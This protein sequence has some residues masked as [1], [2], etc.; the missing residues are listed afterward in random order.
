MNSSNISEDEF[1]ILTLLEENRKKFSQR[2]LA[3]KLQLSLGK[4]NS[5]L[6]EMEAKGFVSKGTITNEGLAALEPY[7]VKRVI[8]LAAGFGSRLIPVTLN[9]PK[10]LIRVKGERII[11]SMI[12]VFISNGIEEI[13]IVRGHLGDQFNQLLEKYPSI[14]FIENPIYNE[15]NNISSAFY[16]KDLLENAYICEADIILK[17]PSLIK[18]YQYTSNYCGV[19]CD[20]TDD[21]CL[22]TNKGKISGV[23]VGGKNGYRMVG[24]SYWTQE[25]GKL[26]SEKI[27]E[28]FNQP[29]GREKYW[30]DVP[31]S[32]FINDFNL[33]IRECSFDDFVEIDTFNELKAVDSVYAS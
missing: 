23:S 9:T 18:K 16:A 1:Q 28:I 26:L 3:K 20:V 10:A 30:D 24:I 13:Y 2:E 14:K 31:L 19:K 11:D 33:Y 7:R 15:S 8:F 5:L 32:C 6:S 25:D 12:D 17:N 29:G 21:W 4:I 27:N 22:F